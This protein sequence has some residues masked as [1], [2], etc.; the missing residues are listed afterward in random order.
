MT[1]T[2]SATVTALPTVAASHLERASAL[3][4]R[5]QRTLLGL[6]GAPGAGKSTLA[7]VLLHHLGSQAQGVP[8]DGFHLAN[9]ELDR[10]GRR[11]RKG[12]P[13]TFDSAGFAALLRRLRQQDA[14]TGEVVYAPAFTRDLD[15]PVAG[16]IP[17]FADTP[18]V[19]VEGNYLLLEDGHWQSVAPLLDEVWYVDVAPAQ[20]TQ[21]LIA[22]HVQFGRTPQAAADWAAQTD[23]PNAVRIA[24]TRH[25]AHR[26]FRWDDA[27][28]KD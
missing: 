24:A 18:L 4:S 11:Q 26:I 16:A 2:T 5:G 17:I 6:V 15:E 19:I 14:D 7:D 12:A 27:V 13:D 25:R 23:E 21:Q 8:M 22:R 28:L 10:L 20:R 3:A 9:R 1:A